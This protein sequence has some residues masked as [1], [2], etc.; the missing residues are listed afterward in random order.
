MAQLLA[1]L[2]TTVL[3]HSH[4]EAVPDSRQ[5]GQAD[6]FFSALG[7]APVACPDS[8]SGTDSN[9]FC[10]TTEQAAPAFRSV[11][12]ATAADLRPVSP[13]ASYTD[14][15]DQQRSYLFRDGFMTVTYFPARGDDL[16]VV[17][18]AMPHD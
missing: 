5:E 17:Q 11:V 12:D 6:A 8:L 14:Q 2:L 3:A 16:V 15:N 9:F 1:L 7:A 10:A 4:A 13:W 18:Y